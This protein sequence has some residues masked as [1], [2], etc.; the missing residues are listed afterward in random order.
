MN[1]RPIR[2]T[3]CLAV[4]LA[5]LG[6]VKCS[7]P[8]GAEPLETIVDRQPGPA[9]SP[10]EAAIAGMWRDASIGTDP[11]YGKLFPPEAVAKAI[12]PVDMRRVIVFWPGE[13]SARDYRVP[14][15]R[16]ECA[17]GR[18][19]LS[20]SAELASKYDEA[21]T[22]ELFESAVKGQGYRALDD[23]RDGAD[24]KEW[25]QVLAGRTGLSPESL[26]RWA[27]SRQ[28]RVY[29]RKAGE[30]ELVAI[31]EATDWVGSSTSRSGLDFEWFATR[32]YAHEEPTLAE[33]LAVL[34]PWF[35]LP[36]FDASL[37]Q[38]LGNERVIGCSVGRGGGVTFKEDVREKVAKALEACGFE[39]YEESEPLRGG[40]VQK[41]WFRYTDTTFASITT[42]PNS[43]RT[44][45]GCQEPQHKGTPKLPPRH[46]SLRV[47]W[48][49]RPIL[50]FEQ[51]P[52][53]DASFKR[54]VRLFHDLAERVA[55]KD[56]LVR[57]YQ[58]LRYSSAPRY[59]AVW[60]TSDVSGN[61]YPRNVRPYRSMGIALSG[62]SAR[63]EEQVTT[64][65]VG[66][67]WVPLEGW[68]ASVSLEVHSAPQK[69]PFGTGTL[70][71]VALV[72][73]HDRFF[74]LDAGR[75]ENVIRLT[76][77]FVSVFVQPDRT[78][79]YEYKGQLPS[80][81]SLRDSAEDLAESRRRFLALYAS[82]ESLRDTVLAQLEKLRRLVQDQIPRLEGV[83]VIDYSGVRSDSPPIPSPA[84]RLH[85]P[86]EETKKA[87][88]DQTL[89]ELD[90]REKLVRENYREM[91][92]AINKALPL[93]EVLDSLLA[94]ENAQ[95]EGQPPGPKE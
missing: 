22:R 2:F 38:S 27:H 43:S 8:T 64:A 70:A 53:S 91:H 81:S 21:Q 24:E 1:P 66:G 74:R 45:F 78:L 72:K 93:G 41:T 86:S 23:K 25:I 63:G 5:A 42:Y 69:V 68:A 90:S 55:A 58:D 4:S 75:S 19:V 35:K 85:P 37:Y 51:L 82:P 31:A 36:W 79:C 59:V 6:G 3:V 87:L 84:A 16:F 57:R 48:S 67:R 56:W 33:A 94:E 18:V 47:P 88:L 54:Q 34:P 76:E 9:S 32:P 71:F 17:G 83:N 26:R 44:L 29:T 80:A 73:A 28:C 95:P 77:Y 7:G 13:K 46:P 11:Q 20:W 40:A 89:A 39:Y 30:T 12:G 14:G 52:F 60:Q 65:G 10:L 62:P 92:A 15:C 61:E 49:K 50:E